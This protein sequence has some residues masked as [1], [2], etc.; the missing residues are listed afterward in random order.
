MAGRSFQG[1]YTAGGVQL[2]GEEV[3]MGSLYVYARWGEGDGMGP[4][5][6]SGR[7]WYTSP[8]G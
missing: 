2:T 4:A 7:R 5:T 6:P 8:P 1:W 3:A